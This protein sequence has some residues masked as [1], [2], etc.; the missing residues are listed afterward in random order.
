MEDEELLVSGSSG[1]FGSSAVLSSGVSVRDDMCLEMLRVICGSRYVH[2]I[3]NC[4]VQE[5]EGVGGETP[6]IGGSTSKGREMG[7]CT[8]MLHCLSCR[9]VQLTCRSQ[10]V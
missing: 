6:R 4:Q 3:L 7:A 5:G 10:E 1:C 2:K 8:A 9:Q